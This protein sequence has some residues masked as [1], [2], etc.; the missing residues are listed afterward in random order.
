MVVT[1]KLSKILLLLL[2]ASSASLTLAGGGSY[3]DSNTSPAA[4]PA[5]ALANSTSQQKIKFNVYVIMGDGECNEGSVW[6]AAMSAPNLHLDNLTVVIDKNNFQQTGSTENIMN[7]D[8][9][10]EKWKSFGWN[11][12]EIDGHEISQIIEAFDEDLNNKKPKAII[13][14]TIKGKGFSFTE[15]NNDWHHSILS[16]SFYDK[17][18]EEL[19]K[20]D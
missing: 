6:E 7:T 1:M 4:T 12:K 9:L 13:A 17:A 8:K 20:N 18:I 15:N 5:A 3:D 11:V 16:Q 2:T 14:N 19:N 10:T